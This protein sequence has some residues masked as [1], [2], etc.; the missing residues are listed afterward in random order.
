MTKRIYCN[1]YQG[2]SQGSGKLSDYS[3]Y[4]ITRNVSLCL[5]ARVINKQ[6]GVIRDLLTC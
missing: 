4:I 6:A 3:S 5:K 1:M 2:N